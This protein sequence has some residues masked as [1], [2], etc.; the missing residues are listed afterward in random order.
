MHI[1]LMVVNE[2]IEETKQL[3]MGRIKGVSVQHSKG[4]IHIIKND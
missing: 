3:L 2:V 1:G 4:S